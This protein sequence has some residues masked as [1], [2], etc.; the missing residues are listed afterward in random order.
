MRP[1]KDVR[2]L[3]APLPLVVVPTN[4]AISRCYGL[5]LSS[6]LSCNQNR[7]Q[8]VIG[9]VLP[10]ASDFRC[11]ILEFWRRRRRMPPVQSCHQSKCRSP[12]VLPHLMLTSQKKTLCWTSSPRISHSSSRFSQRMVFCQLSMQEIFCFVSHLRVARNV[13]NSKRDFR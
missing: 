4:V 9:P 3:C 5:K 11:Q 1:A 13:A 8:H 6:V 7:V 2:L 12:T 10:Q